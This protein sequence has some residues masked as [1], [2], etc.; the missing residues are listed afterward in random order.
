MR[1]AWDGK[2]VCFLCKK[3]RSNMDFCARC[4]KI[5]IRVKRALQKQ[6][7]SRATAFPSSWYRKKAHDGYHDEGTLEVD[8]DAMVSHSENGAYVQCW[9]WISND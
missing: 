2:A 5:V 1:K 9:K 8:D 3:T 4:E 7:N 6:A